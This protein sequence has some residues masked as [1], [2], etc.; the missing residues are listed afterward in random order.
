VFAS[1]YQKIKA[2]GYD[3]FTDA[4]LTVVCNRNHIIKQ[5]QSVYYGLGKLL[6]RCK[7]P[8]MS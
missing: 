5:L 4:F 6:S 2:L 7:T 3:F 8:K 1:K